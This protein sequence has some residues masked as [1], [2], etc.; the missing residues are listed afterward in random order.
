VGGNTTRTKSEKIV[1]NLDGQYVRQ[2]SSTPAAQAGNTRAKSNTQTHEPTPEAEP[3]IASASAQPNDSNESSNRTQEGNEAPKAS[4]IGLPRELRDQIWEE[5]ARGDN[6]GR[7][8]LLP[9][10]YKHIDRWNKSFTRGYK[11]A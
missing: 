10:E 9:N 1:R 3:H 7:V 6:S 11:F 4:L 8:R 2:P 5:I